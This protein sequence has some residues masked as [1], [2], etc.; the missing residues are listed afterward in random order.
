CTSARAHG[1]RILFAPAARVVHRGGG[2]LATRYLTARNTVLFA[3][4]HARARDWLRLAAAIGASL[5]LE[6]IRRRRNGYA[7]DVRQLSRGY[8]D[9]LLGRDVPFAALGSRC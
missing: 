2:S 4:K 9:G 3:R 7:R 1:Y 8:I 6:Y 5:P